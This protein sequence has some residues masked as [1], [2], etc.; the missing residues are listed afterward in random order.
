IKTT[1]GALINP[2]EITF[3][4]RDSLGI[5]HFDSF[6]SEFGIE[7]PQYS[8][9]NYDDPLP[10]SFPD[11]YVINSQ[12]PSPGRLFFSNFTLSNFNG[13]VGIGHGNENRPR[14]FIAPY[15]IIYDNDSGVYYHQALERY[16]LDFKVARNGNLIYYAAGLW[17][18]ITM[19]TNYNILDTIQCGNGYPTDGHE[20]LF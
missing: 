16:G 4:I 1:D 18:Y 10:A 3:I 6:A 9:Y 20:L 2:K 8:L 7:T 5:S 19:D 17:K 15:L 12:S 13:G 14:R 11:L